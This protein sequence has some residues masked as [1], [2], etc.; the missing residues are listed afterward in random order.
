MLAV[1][2]QVLVDLVGDDQEIVLPAERGDRLELSSRED[3]PR[4]VVRR[5]EQHQPRP[6]RHR[7]RERVDGE[8]VVGWL[9]LHD[10]PRG[11]RHRDARGVRVVV[12]LERDHLVARLAQRQQRGGD[13]LGRARGD[14]HLGVGV[15]VEVVPVALVRADGGAQL[16]DAGPRRVL[17]VAGADGGDG[18][19]EHLLRSVGVGEALPEVDRAGLDRERRHLREDRGA[20]A[21]EA[22]GEVGHAVGHVI[23]PG[24]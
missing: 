19:V 16:G 6:R 7:G 5:V 8:G 1:E 9:Q 4:R 21:L 18:G 3:L 11:T 17:V 14:E 13:R 22:R 10:A 20:E 2:D 23:P 12:G 24:S 15:V